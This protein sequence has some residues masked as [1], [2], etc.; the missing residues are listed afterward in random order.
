MLL[1]RCRSVHTFGMSFPIAVIFLD[2]ESRVTSVARTP[3]GRILFC[4]SARHVLECHVGADVRTGD[5]LSLAAGPGE[6]ATRHAPGIAR[7][8]RT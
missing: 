3:T 5:V 7:P 8:A 4:R 1:E 6:P 2:A